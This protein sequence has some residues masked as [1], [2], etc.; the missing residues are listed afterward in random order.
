MRRDGS[1]DIVRHE[2]TD[3]TEE[4][5]LFHFRGMMIPGQILLLLTRLTP[6]QHAGVLDRRM[7]EDSI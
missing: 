7:S 1:H 3:M 5:V 6:S 2:G 4:V